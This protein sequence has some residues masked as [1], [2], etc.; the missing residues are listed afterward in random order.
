MSV[1]NF[2][3]LQDEWS[4][5]YSNVKIAEERVFTEPVSCAGYCRMVLEESIHKLYA[6]EHLEKPFNTELVNLLQDEQ[7]KNIIPDKIIEGLGYVRKT[8]NNA[9]HYGNRITAQDSLVSIKYLYSYLKW[10]A[11]AYSAAVIKT[12]GL[13]D[14]A[15][16]PKVGETGRKIKSSKKITNKSEKK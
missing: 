3:F 8:G 13:F 5:L 10:F 14:E 1:S 11:T 2:Q 15:L 7:V 6:L 9:V 16:I 4:S 12:P